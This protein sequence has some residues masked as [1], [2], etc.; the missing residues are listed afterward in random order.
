M[1]FKNQRTSYCRLRALTTHANEPQDLMD[2]WAKVHQICSCGNFVIDGVNTTIRVA[3]R[4]SV[5]EWQGRY[6]KKESNAGKT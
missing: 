1:T 6:L 5:V 4:P 2:Y 3:I